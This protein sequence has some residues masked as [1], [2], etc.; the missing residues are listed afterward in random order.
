MRIV[1]E[2]EAA[3][4][5]EVE[6][7]LEDGATN[8]CQ[9][10]EQIYSCK[11]EVPVAV[12]KPLYYDRPVPTPVYKKKYI[13]YKVIKEEK[14]YI[15]KE[16]PVHIPVRIPVKVPVNIEVPVY[17]EHTTV[18]PV[19]KCVYREVPHYI[20]QEKII[21]EHVP[22]VCT[23]RVPQVHHQVVEVPQPIKI[24]QV[25][26]VCVKPKPVCCQPKPACC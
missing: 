16:V 22:K 21:K 23:V 11:K 3:E 6:M 10:E 18:I 13:P 8:A 9:L 20:H 15:K 5:D 17:K 4:L 1:D 24:T 25:V 14:V 26:P 2:P 12:E 7:E 19:H